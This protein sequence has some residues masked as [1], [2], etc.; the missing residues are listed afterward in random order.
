MT[1]SG[2]IAVLPEMAHL[3]DSIDARERS[4]ATE[5]V[6]RH[7]D[8]VKELKKL[9]DALGNRISSVE[10]RQDQVVDQLSQSSA[11]SSCNGQARRRADTARAPADAARRHRRDEHQPLSHQPRG[12]R[13]R[14]AHVGCAHCGDGGARA[15][16][17]AA[18]G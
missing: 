16:S 8:T 10:S 2:A 3:V 6:A 13:R 12:A 11:S 9:R 15:A 17:G 1:K 4:L 14:G 18:L 5:V 7:D